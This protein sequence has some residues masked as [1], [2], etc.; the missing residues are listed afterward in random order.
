MGCDG[1]RVVMTYETRLLQIKNV[2]LYKQLVFQSDK[3][4]FNF[5]DN[6]VF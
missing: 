3:K 6:L 4:L 2:F 1:M 5:I